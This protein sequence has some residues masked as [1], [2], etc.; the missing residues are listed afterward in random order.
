VLANSMSLT[1]DRL[2]TRMVKTLRLGPE[3]WDDL[4]IEL[5]GQI[6]GEGVLGRLPLEGEAPAARLNELR[7]RDEASKEWS[8]DDDEGWLASARVV[9]FGLRLGWFCGGLRR[10][11]SGTGVNS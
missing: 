3:V 2:Q 10:N 9:G 11:V 6:R 7:M 4:F 8:E 1:L 5:E